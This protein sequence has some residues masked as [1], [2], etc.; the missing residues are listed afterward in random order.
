[1]SAADGPDWETIKNWNSSESQTYIV[2]YDPQGQG[3]WAWHKANKYWH[4]TSTAKIAQANQWEKHGNDWKD[5]QKKQKKR[6]GGG[7]EPM[8]WNQFQSQHS[9]KNLSRETVQHMWRQYKA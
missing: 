8:N 4:W 6:G 3:H 5:W 1:M 7:S 9:R 2:F